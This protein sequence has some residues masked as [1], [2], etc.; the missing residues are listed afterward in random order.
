MQAGNGFIT[1]NDLRVVMMNLGETLN[2]E[3]CEQLVEEADLDGD[4]QGR[5][6]G[7]KTSSWMGELIPAGFKGLA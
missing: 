1:R 5:R 3:E 2:D 6:R 7:S 4:G